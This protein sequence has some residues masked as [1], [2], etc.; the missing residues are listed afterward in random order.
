[1]DSHKAQNDRLAKALLTRIK[2]V[3]PQNSDPKNP[4]ITALPKL[5]GP[6]DDLPIPVADPTVRSERG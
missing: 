6:S 1:M 2:R 4:P 5:P 3:L